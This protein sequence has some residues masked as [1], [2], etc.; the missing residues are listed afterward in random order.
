[1]RQATTDLTVIALDQAMEHTPATHILDTR[2]HAVTATATPQ[3]V[4]VTT[5]T[6][7]LSHATLIITEIVN[8]YLF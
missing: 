6:A 4:D 1:M 8:N 5:I 3:P 2:L 7:L